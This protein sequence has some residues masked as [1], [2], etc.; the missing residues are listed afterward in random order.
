VLRIIL[1]SGMELWNPH[2]SK[3]YGTYWNLPI[4]G[5]TCHRFSQKT[6]K[7]T[8]YTYKNIFFTTEDFFW[9]GGCQ[10]WKTVIPTATGI[11]KM[12]M[13]SVKNFQGWNIPEH[14]VYR[15]PEFENATFLLSK[16]FFLNF[17]R[18]KKVEFGKIILARLFLAKREIVFTLVTIL[19]SIS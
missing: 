13:L 9:G 6:I 10:N 18:Q 16:N 4:S 5:T 15:A 7:N 12:Y 8:E 1:T 11:G 19:V 17:K 14:P 3:N 2:S